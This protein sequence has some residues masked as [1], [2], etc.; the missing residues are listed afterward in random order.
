[1]SATKSGYMAT[2][3]SKVRPRH[4]EVPPAPEAIMATSHI[5]VRARMRS[6][7]RVAGLYF[8]QGRSR[9]FGSLTKPSVGESTPLKDVTQVGIVEEAARQCDGSP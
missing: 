7:R 3:A 8:C 1:M 9:L 2:D 6:K 5:K 4:G